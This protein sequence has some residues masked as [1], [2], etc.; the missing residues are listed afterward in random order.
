M[1]ALALG[2]VLVLTGVSAAG[3]PAKSASNSGTTMTLGGTGT[4]AKAAA[5][6]DD[7]ALACCWRH[8]GCGYGWGG[9]YAATAWSAG[10]RPFLRPYATH[11]AVSRGLRGGFAYVG[12]TQSDVNAPL[13][14]LNLSVARNPFAMQ[15]R[16]VTSPEAQP[17]DGFR[18]DGGPI[19]PVPLP[20]PD[21]SPTTQAQVPATGLPVSLPKATKPS[22]PYTYKAYGEKR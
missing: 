2:A 9:G 3:D 17:D 6:T 13:V 11:Y 21:S 10:Y 19:N 20:R 22:S 15:A 16:N 1:S 12:A 4:A 8:W 5:S 7:T 18:Y 14:S